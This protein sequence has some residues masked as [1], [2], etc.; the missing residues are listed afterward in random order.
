MDS[1]QQAIDAIANAL[2]TGQDAPADARDQVTTN[3]QAAQNTLSG[4]TS[5]V[6]TAVL[7]VDAFSISSK[8]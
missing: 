2:L 1:A 3:F 4:I 5:C 7:P 8:H 6:S